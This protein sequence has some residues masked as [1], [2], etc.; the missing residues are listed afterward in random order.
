MTR[1]RNVGPNR[2]FW[3]AG[4]GTGDDYTG[5]ELWLDMK[6]AVL[7]RVFSRGKYGREKLIV[8][9][10]YSKEEYQEILQAE[11]E[12]LALGGEAGA[13]ELVQGALARL[14]VAYAIMEEGGS[15][16]D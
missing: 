1:V 2:L 3:S 15:R 16:V 7:R 6:G 4:R 8:E 5:V 10:T 13:R 11:G 12:L 14:R 9:E